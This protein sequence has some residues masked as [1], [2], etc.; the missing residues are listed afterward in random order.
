MPDFTD[1][2][3][4]KFLQS[5]GVKT[6]SA[7]A[8]TPDASPAPTPG[9]AQAAPAGGGGEKPSEELDWQRRASRGVAK[10]AARF[11][12]NAMQLAGNVFP[13]M[14]EKMQFSPTLNRLAG[15][16]RE[17][18]DE[19]SEDWA[20]W[21][22]SGAGEV[23]PSLMMPG[24][25]ARRVAGAIAS[26]LPATFARGGGFAPSGAAR[27]ITGTGR[28]VDAA[29]KGA[30]AGAIANPEDPGAGAMVGGAAGGAGAVVG[31]AMRS[32]MGQWLGGH[33]PT[34]G[35]SHLAATAATAAGAPPWMTYPLAHSIR[36]Y[37]SPL[38]RKLHFAG[39]WITDQTGRIIGEIPPGVAGQATSQVMQ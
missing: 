12:S 33:V 23:V 15:Q 39:R 13:G 22:G 17:F 18:G 28:V 1:A 8:P 34:S 32:P 38:G 5:R 7:P 9:S 11:A 31:P 2:D 3:I 21:F 14:A 6:Q 19:P 37:S 36:W 25:G 10:G 35:L 16:M 4:E 20:Q 29:A 26:R 30:E 27:A 24:V